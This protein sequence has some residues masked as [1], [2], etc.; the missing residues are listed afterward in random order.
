MKAAPEKTFNFLRAK[1]S[2]MPGHSFLPNDCRQTREFSS[3][4][5][6]LSGF[7]VTKPI[8]VDLSCADLPVDPR[9]LGLNIG[10]VAKQPE[11]Q[12]CAI[13]MAPAFDA[14]ETVIEPRRNRPV[15][16]VAR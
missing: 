14:P 10:R 11:F 2:H 7:N 1:H 13:R 4:V 12:Y 3:I 16:A 15:R 9:R 5:R 6:I 8:D